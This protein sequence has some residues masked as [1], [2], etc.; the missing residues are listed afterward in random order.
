MHNWSFDIHKYGLPGMYQDSFGLRK[1][2]FSLT[3]DPAFLFLT[4]QHR[5]A[6]VGLTCA[7]L[8]RKGLS[9]LTG[10]AGAGKTTLLVR[11]LQFL[12]ASRLQCSVIIHPTLTPDEFLELALLDFGVTDIPASKAQRLWK[13]RTLVLDG[14]REGKVSALI[15]DE[16]HKLSPDVLEEIRMLG[17]F[18]DADQKCLQVLLVGQPELDQTLSREDLRQ[19]KQRISVRLYLA[20]LDPSQVGEYI[21]HRWLRA[22]GMESPFSAPAIDDIALISQGIP[23]V[24]SVLCDNALVLAFERRSSQVLSSHVR[25]AAATLDFGE[26]P[27]RPARRAAGALT[28][29]SAPEDHTGF[30]IASAMQQVYATPPGDDRSA[31]ELKPSRLARWAGRLRFRLGHDG[32]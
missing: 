1:H 31:A 32:A 11:M 19:L 15:V 3:P 7:V 14:Q 2:P 26:L 21:R 4:E 12:P 23:R 22:G 27:S 24:I 17:N 13:L 20:P 10:D 29:A 5:A 28:N 18:E 6:L 16:A 30:D 25:E 8:Q 9:V